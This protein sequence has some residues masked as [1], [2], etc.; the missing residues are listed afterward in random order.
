MTNN[1]N[2]VSKGEESLSAISNLEIWKNKNRNNLS[3]SSAN[4]KKNID[5]ENGIQGNNIKELDEE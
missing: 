2:S 5:I 3:S 4:D 1:S